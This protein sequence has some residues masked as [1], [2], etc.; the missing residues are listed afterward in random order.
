MIGA[1]PIGTPC[2]N[3]PKTSNSNPACRPSTIGGKPAPGGPTISTGT[4]GGI[5]PIPGNYCTTMCFAMLLVGWDCCILYVCW[6]DLT[7]QMPALCCL[8]RAI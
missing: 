8:S 2:A 7:A 5:G 6:N 4:T 3:V 1:W